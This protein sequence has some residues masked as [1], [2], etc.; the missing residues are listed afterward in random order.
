MRGSDLS[1]QNRPDTFTCA[2][3]EVAIVGMPVFHVGVSFCCAGCVA[4]G[5]CTCSYDA[6]IG[7]QSAVP[8]A[9]VRHCA[10]LAHAFVDERP[11]VVGA[12][13]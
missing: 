11:G 10:D 9:S 12:A 5:P 3:C 7:G 6:A 1:P 4:N 13:R 8:A 2:T